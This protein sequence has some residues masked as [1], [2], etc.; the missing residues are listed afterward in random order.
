MMKNQII[1]IT[2]ILIALLLIFTFTEL[3]NNQTMYFVVRNI[4]SFLIAVLNA[5]DSRQTTLL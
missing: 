4:P 5:M 2:G 1:Y 3:A